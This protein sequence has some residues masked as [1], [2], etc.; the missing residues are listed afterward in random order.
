MKIV[1][2]EFQQSQPIPTRFTCLGEDRSVPLK[3]LE[4]PK[5]TKTFA[6]IVD[7]PDAPSGVFT[8]WVA[9]NIPAETPTLSEGQPA[10]QEGKN[11]FGSVGYRGPCP[12]PGKPHRYFF[13]VFALD[14][15][16]DLPKGSTKEQLEKAMAGHI[17][18]QAELVGTFQRTKP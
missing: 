2:P 12:P 6:I 9:W 1:S 14:T 10:P 11:S 18:A 4:T 8:H 7:D 5:G 16:L 17:L 3:F 13:K 15:V